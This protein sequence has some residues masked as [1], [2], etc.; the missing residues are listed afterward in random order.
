M[1]Q[2]ILSRS[3]Q[4]SQSSLLWRT[5]SSLAEDSHRQ[6]VLPSIRLSLLAPLSL[7]PSSSFHLNLRVVISSLF[8]VF[9]FSQR[10]TQCK[11]LK[12]LFS[13][14]HDIPSVILMPETCLGK[15]VSIS[16]SSQ[17]LIQLGPASV[18]ERSLLPQV[19]FAS[20]VV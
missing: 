7:F 19:S 18:N 14:H 6:S 8:V 2:H 11:H 4:S 1:L 13:F 17:N 9:L 16:L 12:R 15:Q 5:F 3:A 10:I 20:L